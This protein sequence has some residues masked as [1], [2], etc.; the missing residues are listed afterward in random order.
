MRCAIPAQ[1]KLVGTPGASVPLSIHSLLHLAL[2]I[3]PTRSATQLPWPCEA[4][5]LSSPLARPKAFTSHLAALRSSRLGKT[6]QVPPCLYPSTYCSILHHLVLSIYPAKSA[7]QLPWHSQGLLLA[8]PL[9]RPRGIPACYLAA[10][11]SSSLGKQPYRC[12]CTSL[13]PFPYI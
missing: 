1:E 12:L 2:C 9:A 3:Y 4:L 10:L 11:R 5:L 7:A 6:L 13:H 8:M